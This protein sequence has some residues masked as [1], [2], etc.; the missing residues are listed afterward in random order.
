MPAAPEKTETYE[1]LGKLTPLGFAAR[2]GNFSQVQKLLDEGQEAD[3]RGGDL[4]F[5][6]LHLACMIESGNAPMVELLLSKGA[7]VALKDNTGNIPLNIAA[8]KGDQDI[9]KMLLEAGSDI[10]NVNRG[11]WTPIN[12]AVRHKRGHVAKILIEAG[13]D[14]NIRNNGV[15]A[16]R[17]NTPL[18]I[19]K[20]HRA[21]TGG[22]IAYLDNINILALLKARTTIEEPETDAT[23]ATAAA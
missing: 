21:P 4:N 23:A 20:S 9:V 17:G 16:P 13:A 14:C 2:N 18:E 3:Q 10:N 22:P 1:R 19:M 6:V 8:E 5:T 12:L 11:G 7:S 15:C